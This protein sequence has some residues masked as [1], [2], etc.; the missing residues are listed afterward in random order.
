MDLYNEKTYAGILDAYI[1][2]RY[3]KNIVFKSIVTL[4]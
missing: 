2:K 1:I 3:L 4:C